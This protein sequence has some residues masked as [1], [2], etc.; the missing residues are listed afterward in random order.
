MSTHYQP[1]AN[2]LNQA[3]AQ[4][5]TLDGFDVLIALHVGGVYKATFMNGFNYTESYNEEELHDATFPTFEA[6]KNQCQ[7]YVNAM[8]ESAYESAYDL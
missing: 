1:K 4:R 2:P 3:N 5:I 8:L 7:I 6:A